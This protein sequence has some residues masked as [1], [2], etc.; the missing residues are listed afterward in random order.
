MNM[1]RAKIELASSDL[2]PWSASEIL[3]KEN[4][5]F[6]QKLNYCFDKV[7]LQ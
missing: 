2:H 5:F 7:V 1:C 3:K 6:A 4:P